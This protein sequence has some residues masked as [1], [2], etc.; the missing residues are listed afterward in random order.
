MLTS[1]QYEVFYNG[2]LAKNIQLI[3]SPK[4]YNHCHHL[5][6]SYNKIKS[7]TPVSNWTKPGDD[8]NERIW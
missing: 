7:L 6:E 5:P 2:L 1:N 4:E 8:I 3:N